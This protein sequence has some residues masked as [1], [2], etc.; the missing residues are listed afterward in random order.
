MI[1]KLVFLALLLFSHTAGAFQG[2]LNP[3]PLKEGQFVYTVPPGYAPDGMSPS[4]LTQLNG[5][6]AKLHNPFYVVV[7]EDLP[8]LGDNHRAYARTN[9]F[10]GDNE[11]LRVEVTTAMLME[12]WASQGG[13]ES[14]YDARNAG[15]FV[16]A[17]DPRKYAWHPSQVALHDL[18]MNQTAQKPYTDLFVAAAKTRPADYGRGIGQLAQAYDEYVF[19]QTDPIRIAQRAEISRRANEQRQLW[20]AQ[21]AL[22]KQILRLSELLT[23]D[24]YLPPNVTLYKATWERANRVRHT[25]NPKD[26]LREAETMTPSVDVLEKYVDEQRTTAR[27]EFLEQAGTVAIIV[28]LSLGSIFLLLLRRRQQKWEWTLFRSSY[29]NWTNR[30]SYAQS[31]W[32]EHYMDRDSVKG[33][34]K[35]TG[36]TKALWDQTTVLV[37]NILIRINAMQKH[38]DACKDMFSK[39]SY[40]NFQPYKQAAKAL[41][42]P[43]EFDTGTINESDLF[44]AETVILTVNPQTFTIETEEM[45]RDSING[46]KRLQTAA[47]ERIGQACDDFPHTTLTNM[48]AMAEKHGIP[49]RWLHKHPLYGDETSDLSFYTELDA[50]RLV[51]PVAYLERL[52][53]EQVAEK[54]LEQD[55]KQLVT[56]ASTVSEFRDAQWEFRSDTLVAPEDDPNVTLNAA[57]MADHK[58]TAMLITSDSVDEVTGQ[59]KQVASLYRKVRQQQS[60]IEAAI[61]MVVKAIQ[62]TTGMANRI[63]DNIK[64]ATNVVQAASKVH[65][66]IQPAKMALG[67]ALQYIGEGDTLLKQAKETLERKHHLDAHRLA[68]KAR[69]AYQEGHNKIADAS[70]YCQTLDAE[71]KRFQF[72]MK[73]LTTAQ[74]DL[75]A[76]MKRFGS[77][78]KPLKGF[79]VPVETGAV[80]DFAALTATVEHQESMWRSQ[81]R[82]AESAYEEEQRSIRRRRE[83]EDHQRRQILHSYNSSSTSSS[84]GG[85]SGDF[86]GGGFG[87][88]SGDF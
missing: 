80:N 14:L 78:A 86:G 73:Q 9:G 65:K 36:K 71:K 7:L 63:E 75:T 21:G 5:E 56:T 26:M 32:A 39:G 31:R 15:V 23:E 12:D 29:A 4:Q 33:L 79:V 85:S 58:F 16:I 51:D 40:F 77:H 13:V 18:R 72:Q 17:F 52:S 27:N 34:D 45:F 62:V 42:A 53:H 3:P 22:D 28:F 68:D 38:A 1:R 76:K 41:S 55:L 37:D 25:N 69:Q 61:T 11:T 19:D 83:A 43:F 59:G 44:G 49:V 60:E 82:Q 84:F 64:A 24:E 20:A 50:L 2:P 10:K 81:V 88:S 46:W 57:R 47:K 67:A 54:Q 35:V 66:Q 30:V 74:S 87:G 48:F 70:R 6:L 8:Q